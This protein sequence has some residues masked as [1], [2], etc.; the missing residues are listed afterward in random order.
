V[1]IEEALYKVLTEDAGVS[2]L[3]ADRIYPGFLAQTVT[4]PA[5]AYR[6]VNR[7]R[8]DQLT[9]RR[10]TGLAQSRFRFFCTAQGPDRYAE[11]KRLEDA[12]RLALEG[13]SGEV[14]GESPEA[15][16]IQTIEPLGVNDFYDDATQT[17]QAIA[18]YDVW[19]SEQQPES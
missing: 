3:V 10:S 7:S 14:T 5:I 9:D 8:V 6:L 13:Y 16:Y 11:A 18:D 15:V 19:A 4:Y 17:H 12:V 2:E 1:L